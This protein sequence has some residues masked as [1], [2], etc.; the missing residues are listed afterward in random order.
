MNVWPVLRTRDLL[1]LARFQELDL[2]V[3]DLGLALGV[4]L[5]YAVDPGQASRGIEQP[6]RMRQRGAGRGSTHVA[7]EAH[8]LVEDHGEVALVAGNVLEAQHGAPAARPSASTCPPAA[9]FKI[10]LRHGSESRPSRAAF[11]ATLLF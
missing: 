4:Q 2:A 10:R 7:C 11:K 9:V 1:T 5:T 8:V 3:D 6:Y